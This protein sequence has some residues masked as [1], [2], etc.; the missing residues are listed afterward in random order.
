MCFDTNSILFVQFWCRSILSD[1]VGVPKSTMCVYHCCTHLSYQSYGFSTQTT[2]NPS[3]SPTGEKL[4][5][6]FSFQF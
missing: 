1:L 2:A 5:E 4:Y 6:V 3:T